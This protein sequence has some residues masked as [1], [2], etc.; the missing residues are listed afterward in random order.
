M[1]TQEQVLEIFRLSGGLLKGH[2]RL[3]SGL[4]SDSF[5][6]SA[7]VLQYPEYATALCGAIADRIK[8][9]PIDMVI[10]PAIGGVIIAY[11]V[12]KAMDARAMFGEKRDGKMMLRPGFEI[13]AGERVVVVDDVL[14]TGGSVSQLI[15]IVQQNGASVVAT[16]FIVDRSGNFE[17]TLIIKDEAIDIPKIA[18][19][20]TVFPT[21]KPERCPMCRSGSKPV[22]P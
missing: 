15:D 9:R 22:E 18:L 10:G 11:E 20:T 6:Q 14:T 17:Q 4:H 19:V 1:L 5:L 21:Y 13:K 16:G 3:R 8:V 2:F 7:A 12:A